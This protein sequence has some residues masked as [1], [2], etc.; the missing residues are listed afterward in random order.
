MP[1]TTTTRTK[2]ETIEE[3]RRLARR[4]TARGR[5][6][7]QEYGITVTNNPASLFQVLCLAVLLRRP[8]DFH[9]A[10]ETVQALDARGWQTP[11]QLARSLHADRVNMLRDCGWRGDVD[12]LASVLGDLARTV[13]EEYRGDLRRLRAPARYDAARERRALTRLPGVDEQVVELFLR[14]AQALWPEAAP[15]VDR[16]TLTV[17]R[18]LGLGGSAA[19]L[20]EVVRDKPERLAWLVGA[21][22]RMDLERRAA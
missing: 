13:T 8:G 17:A 3:R 14:E 10:V 1:T 21:L 2:T 7:A 15:V 4:L 6:F 22:A 16:R 19:E 20:A 5:G 12:A 11:N 9:R 18:R